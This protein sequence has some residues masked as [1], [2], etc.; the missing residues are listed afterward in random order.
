M[1]YFLGSSLCHYGNAELIGYR[2]GNKPWVVGPKAF[3]IDEDREY[4]PPENSTWW[5]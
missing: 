1:H 5:S 2:N 3:D 4:Q